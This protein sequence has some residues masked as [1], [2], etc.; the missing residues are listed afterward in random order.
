MT[1]QNPAPLAVQIQALKAERNHK[2]KLVAQAI[3]RNGEAEKWMLE[4]IH[5]LESAIDT[6]VTV[7]R[8]ALVASPEE[9]VSDAG[10]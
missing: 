3:Q 8:F 1:M 4:R 6:L 9:E 5:A 2:R 10:E 7:N